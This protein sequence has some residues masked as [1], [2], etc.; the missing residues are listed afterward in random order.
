M[1]CG[2]NH[3]SSMCPVNQSRGAR[4]RALHAP[5]TELRHGA[6]IARVRDGMRTGRADVPTDLPRL[7]SLTSLNGII[8]DGA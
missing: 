1:T 2:S 8:D 5:S 4:I 7:S 3:V 6:L